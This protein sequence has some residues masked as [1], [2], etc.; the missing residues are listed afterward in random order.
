M[1]GRDRSDGG[2]GGR[3]GDGGRGPLFWPS[4]MAITRSCGTP[5]ALVTA[6]AVAVGQARPVP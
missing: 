5:E 3:I 2:I 6:V 4:E 1:R